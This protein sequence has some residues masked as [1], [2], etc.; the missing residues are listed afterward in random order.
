M[1]KE[2]GSILEG[3]MA[4]GSKNGSWVEPCQKPDGSQNCAKLVGNNCQDEDGLLQLEE[5]VQCP[6][7]WGPLTK[8][9]DQA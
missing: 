6:L 7:Q 1:R 8:V 3:R 2:I 5:K 9:S 4:L